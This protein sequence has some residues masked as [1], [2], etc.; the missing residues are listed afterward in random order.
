MIVVTDSL[1]HVIDYCAW[2]WRCLTDSSML[3]H[4]SLSLW[5]TK[6]ATPLSAIKLLYSLP[7]WKVWFA[8]D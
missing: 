8:I 4:G 5:H 6:L 3:L 7:E 1:W 2:C